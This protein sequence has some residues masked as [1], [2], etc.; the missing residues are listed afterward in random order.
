M[1]FLFFSFSIACYFFC[2]GVFPIDVHKDTKISPVTFILCDLKEETK[3]FKSEMA[4]QYYHREDHELKNE[5]MPEIV[6]FLNELQAYTWHFD[7]PEVKQAEPRQRTRGYHRDL[8]STAN[9][10]VVRRRGETEQYGRQRCE[11]RVTKLRS[12]LNLETPNGRE[13][14]RLASAFVESLAA[15]QMEPVAYI[16]HYRD[17]L[18]YLLARLHTALDRDV[19]HFRFTLRGLRVRGNTE[20]EMQTALDNFMLDEYAPFMEAEQKLRELRFAEG[21]LIDDCEQAYYDFAMLLVKECHNAHVLSAKL[22]AKHT[23]YLA[24]RQ[25]HQASTQTRRR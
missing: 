13:F 24:N 3:K 18:Y 7:Q 14:T 16:E 9:E 25:A 17:T 10:R 5:V 15:L 2:V 4:E 21:T 12:L 11:E 1:S 20:E 8:R 19:K 22:H 23:A 6:L